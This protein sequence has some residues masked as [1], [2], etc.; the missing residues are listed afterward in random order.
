MSCGLWSSRCYCRG[1]ID[2]PARARAGP[3]LPPR[4]PVRPL[5]RQSLATPAL[6]PGSVPAK[7]CWRRLDRW[8]KKSQADN[9]RQAICGTPSSRKTRRSPTTAVMSFPSPAPTRA[10]RST[11]RPR[12]GLCPGDRREEAQW[13]R[14]SDR[15]ATVAVI[16][17]RAGTRSASEATSRALSTPTSAALRQLRHLR[18]PGRRRL[19][20]P[21]RLLADCPGGCR[22]GQPAVAGTTTV[23]SGPALLRHPRPGRNPAPTPPAPTQPAKDA[24]PLRPSHPERNHLLKHGI[25]AL[26]SDTGRRLIGPRIAPGD[27]LPVAGVRKA[28]GRVHQRPCGDHLAPRGQPHQLR[29]TG[30][31]A[32]L[33]R[34]VEQIH[35]VRARVLVETNRGTAPA[36][37]SVASSIR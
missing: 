15:L 37:C 18:S 22:P 16:G 27:D 4:H 13:H 7:T 33:R 23:G 24:P 35:P 11:G 30:H 8:Q 34:R 32:L 28:R 12:Q 29:L 31:H 17:T 20:A 9:N 3:A 21:D 1:R 14:P 19:P 36:R 26:R 5:Q 6:E 2:L 25:Q 10:V